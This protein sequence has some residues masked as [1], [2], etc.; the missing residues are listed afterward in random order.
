M[1]ESNVLPF[2]KVTSF[3]MPLNRLDSYEG[4]KALARLIREWEREKPEHTYKLLAKRANL[5]PPT[6]SKIASETT[7]YPRLHTILSIMVAL[8]FTAV[9]FE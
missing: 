2:R 3:A 6:V 7:V 5:T 1:N 8:G 4:R 9:R